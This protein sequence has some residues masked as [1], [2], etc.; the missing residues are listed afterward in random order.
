[1]GG[2]LR[3]RVWTF[4]NSLKAAGILYAVPVLL[5]IVISVVLQVTGMILEKRRMKKDGSP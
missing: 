2:Y 1:M 3:L 4:S 5:L